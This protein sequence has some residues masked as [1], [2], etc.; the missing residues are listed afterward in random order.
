[1]E[2]LIIDVRTP[3]EF[4]AGHSPGSVNIPMHLIPLKIEELDRS[5]KLL[6]CCRSGQRSG[7]VVEFLTANGFTNV[8]NIGAWDS[9]KFPEP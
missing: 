9:P 4:A 1:M 7:R 6:F 5:K 3:E 8:Y 2:N